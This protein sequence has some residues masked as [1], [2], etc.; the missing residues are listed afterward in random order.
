M[1]FGGLFNGGPGRTGEFFNVQGTATVFIG[2]DEVL[3]CA[4]KLFL[5][6]GF[7]DGFSWLGHGLGFKLR[8]EGSSEGILGGSGHFPV[9]LH[10]DH[11][12]GFGFFGN[13]G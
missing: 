6:R 13:V 9:V 1:E 10:V 8:T 7:G 3:G 11:G 4:D 5:F 12:F 2:G